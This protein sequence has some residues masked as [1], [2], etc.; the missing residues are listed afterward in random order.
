MYFSTTNKE[1]ICYQDFWKWYTSPEMEAQVEVRGFNLGS[2]A[3]YAEQLTGIE[4]IMFDEARTWE[5]FLS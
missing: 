5:P 4:N 3:T 2:K 1:F